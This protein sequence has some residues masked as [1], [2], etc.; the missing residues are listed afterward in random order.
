MIEPPRV[1]ILTAS[2]GEGHERPAR[3][4]AQELKRQCPGVRVEVVDFLD[5]VSAFAR[6]IVIGGSRFDS[7]WGNR[8][9]D[10]E[11]RLIAEF[12]VTHRLAGALI[13]GLAEGPA[14]RTV[15]AASP[16]VVV[17]T[18]PAATEALGRLK[19]KGR[20][21]LPVVATITDLA[22]LRYWAHPSV[23]LHLIT[24]PEA[25]DE[26]RSVAPA[27]R[28]ECVQGLSDPAF[29]DRRDR[30]EARLELGLPATGPLITVSGGGWGVGDLIGATEE[31]LRVEGAS[32][33]C[34]GGRNESVRAQLEGRFGSDP[35]VAVLGFTEQMPD[36]LAASDVLVHST[37]GGTVLEAIMIGCPIVSYG[38]GRGHVRVNNEAYLREGL[39]EVAGT[40]EELHWALQRCM[41]MERSCNLER[42]AAMPSAAAAVLELA[43]GSGRA[44]AGV[45]PSPDIV[46]GPLRDH[47]GDRRRRAEDRHTNDQ[48]SDGAGEYTSPERGGVPAFAADERRQDHGNSDLDDED[49]GRHAG[50]GG[51]LKGS[52]FRD[53]SEDDHT[54]HE[55]D[56]GGAGDPEPG[57]GILSDELADERRESVG[58][59]SADHQG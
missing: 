48:R 1:L 17:S 19:A 51:A 53:Q 4:L 2:I 26:V 43:R 50:S 12:R 23:D 9:Y 18:Y 38:W 21:D 57:R 13:G 52:R 32:V 10:F 30:L 40:R 44:F 5:V 16:D 55:R 31:S 27:S 46:L 8:L 49:C 58:S 42:F 47:L 34:L 39:A 59:A 33:V 6:R 14:H 45:P 11:Y 22:A 41:G 56:P 24:H 37:A 36:L 35:R 20:L 3:I 25:A 54:G 15:S 7:E 29:Y 28:V